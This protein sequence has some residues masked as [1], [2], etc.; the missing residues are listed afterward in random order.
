M[1]TAAGWRVA[2]YAT[3]GNSGLV[4]WDAFAALEA[5]LPFPLREIHTD[6]DPEFLNGLIPGFLQ[7]RGIAMSRSRPHHKNDNRF[8][9]EN[10]GSHT[11]AYVG[12]GRLDSIAQVRVLNA[13]YRLLDLYHNLFRPLMRRQA[14]GT[15]TVATPLER[16]LQAGFWD[17]ET[18][19]AWRAY[20]DDGGEANLHPP[21][22]HG[23]VSIPHR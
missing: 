20:R 17:A 21:F 7:E 8:V 11:Q 3:L 16:L 15:Y 18:V 2:T 19:Q 10:N 23:E 22:S 14:D 4:M 6:N 13:L 12:Y 5:R 1:S 9:E